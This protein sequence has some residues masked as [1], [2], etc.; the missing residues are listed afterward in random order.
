MR[1]QRKQ[2]FC[3][4]NLAREDA[5][6]L[7]VPIRM[8]RPLLTGEALRRSPLV[9]ACRAHSPGI[10]RVPHV[11]AVAKPKIVFAGRPAAQWASDAWRF[12]SG[13]LLLFLKLWNNDRIVSDRNHEG[14]YYPSPEAKVR[15][16]WA[17]RTEP[18]LPLKA[19]RNP[20]SISGCLQTL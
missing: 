16:D 5:E 18:F 4:Y 20:H 6:S 19:A 14:Y 12:R 7:F 17:D 3:A 13:G 9:K 11:V 15:P 1:F 10:E 8:W 2:A